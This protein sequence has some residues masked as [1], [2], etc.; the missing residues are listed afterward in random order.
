LGIGVSLAGSAV[1][2]GFGLWRV[3]LL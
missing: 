3:M 1:W 2:E